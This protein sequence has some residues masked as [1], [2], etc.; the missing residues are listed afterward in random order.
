M[1]SLIMSR[2]KAL[3]AVT[4][5]T[6]AAVLAACGAATPTAVHPKP[7]TAPA[8]VSAATV[9][10]AAATAPVKPATAPAV[11]PAANPS[12][13][14][15]AAKPAA[16]VPGLGI[17]KG[18]FEGEAKSLTGAGA[19]FPAAL[20]S[21][22]FDEYNK[23]TGVKVNYQSIGSGGGI[24]S[25]SDSTVDFGAT[26][27]P[28]N[29]EQLKA[30]K[31]G[32][33]L[34]VPMAL[35]AVVPTYNIP[36]ITEALKITPETLSAMYLG[37]ITKWNDP[38]LV[39]DN[40]AL[41]D[42]NKDIIVVYRSDGSGTT[43]I[44]TDYLAA[45][46]P[47]WKSKV[48]SATSVKWPVGIGGKGNEGVAGEV[49]QNQYTLGY[50]ELIY[51]VQNKLGVAHM[52][53]STGKFVEPKLDSVTAAAAGIGDKIA[54]DL[55]ASIVNAPGESAYPIS[56]FTWLLA[57]KAQS[58]KPKALALTRLMWWSIYDAQKFNADLGYAPLP[59]AIVAKAAEKI[60]SI[61]VGGEPAFPGK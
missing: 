20:Y 17:I 5:T 16:T 23:L 55:R 21:K 19:T 25:I 15:A 12:T 38:K 61:T 36:G 33:I 10:P 3:L 26:D 2:R 11:A 4:A 49:K 34:H 31:S 51:A 41:K 50:V 22:W 18:A 56:G 14:P 1:H 40:P 24:K 46:S 27:G 48:G 44:F 8:P 45:I 54:P 6:A 29:D 53:N 60:K 39:S 35:G 13:V 43:Y 52:K 9:A 37:T 57:Y 59:E 58:D 28:M 30:A 7:T 42:V 32:E 47:E